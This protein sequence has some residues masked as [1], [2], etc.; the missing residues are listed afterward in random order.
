MKWLV[1]IVFLGMV[2]LDCHAQTGGDDKAREWYESGKEFYQEGKYAEAL[3]AFETAYRLSRRPTL[4]RSIGYCYEKLDRLQEA[5]ETYYKW[6]AV[7]DL[8]KLAEIERHIRRIEAALQTQSTSPQ[9]E[10]AAPMAE[11]PLEAP[12]APVPPE[13]KEPWRVSTGPAVLYGVTTVAVVTGTVM[14][15]QAGHARTEAMANCSTGDAVFCRDS[16]SLP[17]RR[18]GLF[19]VMADA[20]FGVAGAGLVGA[21]LWMVVDNR[22]SN[23]QV[24]PSL[25]GIGFR[26]QF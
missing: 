11:A 5:L 14:A 13:P 4:L 12:I 18:D 19:S 1:T 22:S 9:P 6:R 10:P 23:L 26:G 15:V 21:T 17:I 24:T 16:A 3:V 2:S 20:S 8:A 7:A 25:N